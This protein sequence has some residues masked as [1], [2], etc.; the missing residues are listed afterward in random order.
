MIRLTT[1]LLIGLML[2]TGCDDDGPNGPGQT[3]VGSWD[4]VGYTDHGVAAT[5]ATGTADFAADGSFAITGE[6]IFPGEPIE[7]LD[8]NGVWSTSGD[9]VNLT[10]IDGTGEWGVVFSGADATLERVGPDPTNV[11]QLRRQTL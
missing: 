4:L 7:P 11:I 8:V 1:S 9:R 5:S 3:L 2:L 6:V 10:T